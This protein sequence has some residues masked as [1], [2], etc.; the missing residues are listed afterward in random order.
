MVSVDK[1]TLAKW[2]KRAP[3][4]CLDVSKNLEKKGKEPV[5]ENVK[6]LIVRVGSFDQSLR[7]VRVQLTFSLL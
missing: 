7:D 4:A 6:L 3:M 1:K 5:L 2:M